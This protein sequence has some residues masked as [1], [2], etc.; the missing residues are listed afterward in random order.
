MYEVS[1]L[2][3][4]KHLILNI[5]VPFL[6]WLL[7]IWIFYG[8]KFKWFL[9]Y[10]IAWFLWV[11][12]VGFSL[13]NIQFIHFWV[14]ISEY[15]VV[16]W[17]LLLIFFLKVCI[18][19]QKIKYYIQTLKVENIISPI[20]KSFLSLSITEKA[21]TVV[22]LVYTIYFVFI[23]GMFDFNLPT[24]AVDSFL[25]WNNATFNIYLDWWIKLF[26]EETEILWKWRLWYPIQM[27]TYKALILRFA[28]VSDIYVN[29]RQWL[30]FLFGL[31]FIFSVTFEKTKN[32]FKSIL[33]IWLI[34][35]LPL[36]FFH[37]FEWYMDFPLIMYCVILAWL[38]YQYLETKDFDHLS[39]GLLFWF[40]ASN[41]KNDGLIV[42]FPWL[43]MALFIVLCLNKKLKFTIK[44]FFKDRNNLWK[45]IWYFIY[46]LIPFV[47]VKIINW[48]GFNQAAYRKSW[49]WWADKAHREIFPFFKQIFLKEDNYNLILI[50]LLL[51]LL[52]WFM[53]KRKSYNDA[54]FLLAWLITFLILI[55]VFLF[56]INYNFL[57]DQTAVNRVFMMCFIIVLAFSWFLIDE[58]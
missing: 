22:I 5:L 37:A 20:K 43:L 38:F 45:S 23:S 52:A 1:F 27:P 18:K 25:N 16:L 48:F 24:Y 49:M 46:F 54:L 50:I 19:K 53:K 55:A 8:N 29:M 44:W 33:P 57:L 6:P 51:I 30:V 9:L 40:I 47:I 56:T 41:I 13:L 15:F 10:L 26:G 36:M 31:F 7:F 34:I 17:L 28:W 4:L 42:F 21:F 2:L 12:V 58:K 11:W 35:S 32:V 3:F 14:W 39:L